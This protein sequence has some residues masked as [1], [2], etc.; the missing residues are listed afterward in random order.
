MT[1]PRFAPPGGAP[2]IPNDGIDDAPAIQRA[3]DYAPSPGDI[4]KQPNGSNYT[5]QSGDTVGTVYFPSGVFDFV[6]PPQGGPQGP[7]L[8]L[9]PGVDSTHLRTYQGADGAILRRPFGPGTFLDHDAPILQ[10]SGANAHDILITGLTFEGAGI[11]LEQIGSTWVDNVDVTGCTFRNVNDGDGVSFMLGITSGGRNFDFTGNRFE[12]LDCFCGIFALNVES[13]RIVGNSFETVEV[14][15]QLGRPTGFGRPG[16]DISNNRITGVTRQGVE[17]IPGGDDTATGKEYYY[18]GLAIRNNVISDFRTTNGDFYDPGCFALEIITNVGTNVVIENNKLFGK[19]VAQAP[20]ASQYTLMPVYGIEFSG[21]GTIIRNNL[22]EGFW[23]PSA[24]NAYHDPQSSATATYQGNRFRGEWDPAF[25]DGIEKRTTAT[26][27][28]IGDNTTRAVERAVVVGGDLIVTESTL[29]STDDVIAIGGSNSAVSVTVNGTPA[30]GSPFAV[31]GG[32]VAYGR[33]GN[34]RI[35]V[36]SNVTLPVTLAGGN[37]NDT[38]IAGGGPA[39][40]YGDASDDT[41]GVDLSSG[42]LPP[43]LSLIGG[44]GT[45]AIVLTGSTSAEDL[46]VG[47][48]TVTVN[49]VVMSYGTIETVSLSGPP[50]NL[51]NFNSLTLSTKLA[52]VA[53]QSLTLKL[54]SLNITGGGTLD[55]SDNDM[56][57]DY[58]APVGTLVS[59]VRQHLQAGRIFSSSTTAKTRLGYADN[60][61]F[62]PPRST[63]SGQS[64]DPTSILIKY[65]QAGDADLDG[66]ADGV[67]IGVWATQFTGELGGTGSKVWTQG[68]W[69]YDGD[70]DGVDAGLW[71]AAFTGELGGGGLAT[72]VKS[73]STA[74]RSRSFAPSIAELSIPR[75]ESDSS[76]DQ[77]VA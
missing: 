74:E 68:D 73:V 35:T 12:N 57:L 61:T 31:S 45:D 48:R 72:S 52:L 7:N 23:I 32:I 76:V 22:V 3:I 17:I 8:R 36:A 75:S 58:N 54:R 63:F 11:F 29:T 26:W 9:K 15:I 62:V 46:D 10:G 56:I 37:G 49:S 1:D 42:S 77:V 59:Q 60:N 66:D 18:D 40:I 5:V 30:A 51:L 47:P 41:L 27:N 50:H 6:T 4:V 13:F 21:D 25:P 14:G 20:P 19:L 64:V 70:V 44:S 53:G 65:T 28:V 16:G 39:A 33:D 69:D 24:G 2:A 67:D 71:S 34:D 38:L 43:N 55:L